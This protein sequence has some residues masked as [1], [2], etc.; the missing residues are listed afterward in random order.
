MFGNI[1]FLS[2]KAAAAC[3]ALGF[4][5]GTSALAND[6]NT[7]LGAGGLELVKSPVI[8]MVSEDLYI[9]SSEIKVKYLFKNTSDSAQTVT[10]AFPFDIAPGFHG[11]DRL[12]RIDDPSKIPDE[13]FKFEGTVDGV[14]IKLER[15]I[16]R[17]VDAKGRDVTERLKTL[18]FSLPLEPSYRLDSSDVSRLSSEQWRTLERDG[19]VAKEG[20]GFKSLWRTRVSAVWTQTYAPGQESIVEHRYKPFD[21]TFIWSPRFRD[22]DP[23]T[24]FGKYCLT[25]T[26]A[27]ILRKRGF[28]HMPSL[29]NYILTTA[30]TW[31]GPIGDFHLTVEKNASEDLVTLCEMPLRRTGP[32]TFEMRLK[33]FSPDKELNVLFLKPVQF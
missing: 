30:N 6:S 1:S 21:G 5:V 14:P 25:P 31:A 26:M 20:G 32:T 17:T 8:R 15:T 23:Q 22:P 16:V 7:A 4:A 27:K 2:R 24:V 11:G 9:S 18:G 29:V 19:L 3:L 12:M 13:I 28:E 33:D 10:V